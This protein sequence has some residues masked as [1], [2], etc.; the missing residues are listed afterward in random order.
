[1]NEIYAP[2]TTVAETELNHYRERPET[3]AVPSRPIKLTLDDALTALEDTD[4]ILQSIIRYL[5]GEE[6][7][8]SKLGEVKSLTDEAMTIAERA[9]SIRNMA[10]VVGKIIFG[11]E[12]VNR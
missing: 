9:Y 7:K 10:Q 2:T 6:I 12:G 3:T 4:L 5:T 11:E 1:M 8:G